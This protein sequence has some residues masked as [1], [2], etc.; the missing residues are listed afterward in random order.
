MI[1]VKVVVR[2]DRRPPTKTLSNKSALTATALDTTIDVCWGETRL[3]TGTPSL[4]P[5]RP[6]FNNYDS[7]SSANNAASVDPVEGPAA[8]SSPITLTQAQYQSLM[9]LIQ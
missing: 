4:P 7:S 1:S 6:R 8:S 9:A 2:L 5:C 3:P